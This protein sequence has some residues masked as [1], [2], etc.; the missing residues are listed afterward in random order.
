M[1]MEEEVGNETV[2]LQVFIVA[3]VRSFLA[4]FLITLLL[5]LPRT[6]PVLYHLLPF[7]LHMVRR[8]M[9]QVGV[10]QVNAHL[11]FLSSY[12]VTTFNLKYVFVFAYVK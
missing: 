3:L 12:Q 11:N 1:H 9:F 8:L 6:F 7:L 4:R 2:Q 10:T 5:T